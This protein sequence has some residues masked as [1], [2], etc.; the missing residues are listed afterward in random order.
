LKRTL[1]DLNKENGSVKGMIIKI[2]APDSY[3]G[4]SINILYGK[5]VFPVRRNNRRATATRFTY[6]EV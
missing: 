6:K 2:G 3:S 5:E 1:K 4:V